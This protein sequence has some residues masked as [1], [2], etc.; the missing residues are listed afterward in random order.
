MTQLQSQLNENTMVKDVSQPPLSTARPL[1][2]AH[3]FC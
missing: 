1:V 2:A 3:M